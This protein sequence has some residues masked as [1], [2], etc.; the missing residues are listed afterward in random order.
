MVIFQYVVIALICYALGSVNMAIILSKVLKKG[1]IREQGSKNAGSTNALRVL[2]KWPA[3]VVIIWDI[4]KGVLAVL[5]AH[6]IAEYGREAN[7]AE[8][9]N[10]WCYGTMLAAICV[11]LGHNYPVYFGF[12]GGK[13]VATSLGVILAIEWKIGLACLALG[14]AGIAIT[15]MVSVGSLLAALLYPILVFVMGGTF[16]LKFSSSTLIRYTYIGFSILLALSVFIRHRAN[17]KRIHEGTEN[18]ISFKKKEDTASENAEKE[19]EE[20]KQ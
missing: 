8:F 7:P 10:V 17:I 15:Q 1:D 16:D 3:L 18:R 14:V 5:I 9:N 2:G 19:K 20:E 11:V 12:K 13:G 4:L 6:A